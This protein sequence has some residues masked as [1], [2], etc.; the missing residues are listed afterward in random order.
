MSVLS[1]KAPGQ[2]VRRTA[3]TD[4]PK[5]V[6]QPVVRAIGKQIEAG[7]QN[8]AKAA[9]RQALDAGVPVAVP[10]DNDETLGCILTASCGQLGIPHQELLGSILRS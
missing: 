4:P 8:A 7:F 9:V 10:A 2:R 3:R 5:R 1:V 6:E